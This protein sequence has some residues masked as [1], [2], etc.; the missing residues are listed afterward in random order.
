V[1][2]FPITVSAEAIIKADLS[3]L[4][5]LKLVR[6]TQLAYVRTGANDSRRCQHNVGCTVNVREEE[7]EEVARY[8]YHYRDDFCAVAL[9]AATGDKDYAQAPMEAVATTEDEF[10]FGMLEGN[11]TRVDY[12]QM[13]EFTDTTNPLAEVACAGGQCEL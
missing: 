3:A 7:W 2:S 10:R 1:I 4:A 11:F 13:H 6:T 5:H 12:A 9:L 8:L